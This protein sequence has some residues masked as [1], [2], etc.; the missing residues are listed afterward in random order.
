MVRWRRFWT[1]RPGSF[2]FAVPGWSGFRHACA[3]A[4][5]LTGCQAPGPAP[6]P[7]L[8]EAPDTALPVGPV[9]HCYAL[10]PEASELRVL[11]FKAG[12]LARL[13]HNHVL[14]SS[15]LDARVAVAPDER[16]GGL[17]LRIPVTS[18]EV[19]PPAARAEEG[20]EFESEVSP[21]AR[22]DTRTNLLGP[23]VLDAEQHPFIDVE[24]DTSSGPLWAPDL[25]LRVFLR[26]RAVT[27]PVTAA[28][29]RSG[30]RLSVGS[31]FSVSHT[32]LGL[33]PFSV[34][35][36]G[37]QVADEL[38]IR[39][40]LVFRATPDRE[41]DTCLVPF[42]ALVRATPLGAGTQAAR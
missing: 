3:G 29:A 18:L 15:A 26:G 25:V 9:A 8:G 32:T 10:V 19:D 41:L 23:R 20:P 42:A 4:L 38:K 33:E 1:R 6:A 11:V 28:A 37:L 31:V 21:Q 40:R 16:L 27:L 2:A 30:D 24:L 12:P 22:Q 17:R 7:A 14:T 13:G 5:L 34:L 35:G 39:L 36:G